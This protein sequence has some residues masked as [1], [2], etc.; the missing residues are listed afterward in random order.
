MTEDYDRAPRFQITQML[1]E[2][3]KVFDVVRKKEEPVVLT[4]FGK[5]TF[6]LLPYTEK[7]EIVSEYETGQIDYETYRQA[8]INVGYEQLRSGRVKVNPGAV[9]ASER[10][11]IEREKTKILGNEFLLEAAKF[12]GGYLKPHL[13]IKCGETMIPKE[14]VDKIEEKPAIS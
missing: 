13:C 2:T 14:I 7:I 1:R 10:T 5:D 8:M 6:V 11:E 9:V 12:F 3:R 4:E